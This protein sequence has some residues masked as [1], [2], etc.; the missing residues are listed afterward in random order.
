MLFTNPFT[1]LQ[2]I[3]SATAGYSG[4]DLKALCTEA[5]FGPLRDVTD[6]SR[7][8]SAESVRPISIKDF[9]NALRLARASVDSKELKGLEE[10]NKMYGSFPVEEGMDCDSANLGES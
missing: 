7:I 9:E 2:R 4:A 6:L 3:V 5:A 8:A 1:E 10:W